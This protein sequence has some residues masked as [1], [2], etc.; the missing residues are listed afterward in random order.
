MRAD[1]LPEAAF[2]EG[3]VFPGALGSQGH[4]AGAD[5][6]LWSSTEPGCGAV[7]PGLW[8]SPL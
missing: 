1:P 8:F 3:T 7:C 6:A 4:C 5:V 2:P